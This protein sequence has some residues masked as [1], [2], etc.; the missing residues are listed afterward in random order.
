MEWPS[1][2]NAKKTYETYQKYALF[3]ISS[4][5]CHTAMKF[6]ELAIVLTPIRCSDFSDQIRRSV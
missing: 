6:F 1:Y 4:Q 2:L 3:H 5:T